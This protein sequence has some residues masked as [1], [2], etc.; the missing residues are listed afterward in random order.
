MHVL[1]ISGSRLLAKAL[2][3]ALAEEG[4]TVDLAGPAPEGLPGI[5]LEAYDAIIL[6]LVRPR[7]AGLSLL[8]GWRRGGLKTRVLVLAP[9]DGGLPPAADDWLTKP[10]ELPE[11]LAR[12]RA[13]GRE[14]D[15]NP[16]Q[17]HFRLGD[18]PDRPTVA[19]REAPAQWRPGLFSC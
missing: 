16:G 18:H 12:L 2:R 5:P 17:V 1:L 4:F 3:Q 15:R 6:D 19:Y 10:F 9:P 13:Q 11:L 14:E 8:Q 7:E